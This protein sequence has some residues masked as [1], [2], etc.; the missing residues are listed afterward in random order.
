MSE[1]VLTPK[2]KADLDG[3]WDDTQTNWGTKQATEYV[4]LIERGI[5]T[6]AADP[7]RGR[8]CDEVRSG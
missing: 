4:R 3:I 8:P 6:V 5:K 1:F 2:A 7:R